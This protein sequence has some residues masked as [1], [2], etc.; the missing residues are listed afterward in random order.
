MILG[1][2]YN[3][4]G[5]HERTCVSGLVP[6][7]A[8]ELASFA[9]RGAFIAATSVDI[10]LSIGAAAITATVSVTEPTW[11]TTEK[12][13]RSPSASE[14]SRAAVLKPALETWISKLPAGSPEK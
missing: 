9:R 4:S 1:A 3:A 5:N 11:S 7:D 10:V 2:T 12:I 13:A 14:I 6:S 8:A